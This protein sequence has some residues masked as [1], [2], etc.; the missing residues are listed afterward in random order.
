MAAGH[1]GQVLVSQSTR[2]LLDERFQ[3]RDVGVHRLKDLP[4]KQQLYQLQVEG[5]PA[6]FPPLKTLDH[7]PTNL[8]LE[9]NAFIGRTREL[10]E[11]WALLARA[12]ARPLTLIGTGG[13]RKTRLAR[14]LAA[15]TRGPFPNRAPL[16][17]LSTA[18]H[19]APGGP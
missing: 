10:K 4:G 3:L 5:H 15:R 17:P 9:P 14:R 7:R 8:P 13:T 2:A 6:D 16:G 11:A 18:R 1:G 19:W 12:D